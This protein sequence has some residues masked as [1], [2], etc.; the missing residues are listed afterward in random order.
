MFQDAQLDP[1]VRRYI[2][3]KRIVWQ[4]G[5]SAAIERSDRLLA[6][7]SG[8]AGLDLGQSCLLRHNGRAPGILLDFGRELH[9]GVQIIVGEISF[10]R[11]AR[12]RIRFGESV[13]EAMS[14][15]DESYTPTESYQNDHAIR[16]TVCELPWCGSREIGNTGFR[17]LRIDL[18]DKGCYLELVAV[19]AVLL[20]RDLEYKGSF[21]CDDERLNRIWRTGA[22]TVQLN[23]QGYLWDGIKR[24]RLVW[25]GDMHPETMVISAVFGEQGI[26]PASLD[27]VKARTPLPGWMNGISSYS[28]WWVIIQHSWF[29]YHGNLTYLQEQ[30]AYLTGLLNILVEQIDE[31]DREVLGGMRFLDWPSSNNP[32]AIHAG[33][34]SLL[35]LALEAGAALCDALGE[36]DTGARCRQAVEGLRRHRPPT[37]GAKQAGALMAL[38]GLVDAAEINCSLLAV[39]GARRMS[40]FYGY[41]VLQARALAGDYRGALDAIREYWGAMLDLGATTFWEHFD[42]DWVENACSIDRLVP[43]GM[44][45]I[46]ADFGEYCYQGTRHSLCHGWA[47]GPTA[48]LMEHI[49]GLVPLELGCR[50]IRVRPH[51]ADLA[52]ARGTFPTPLGIVRVEHVKQADGRITSRIHAPE[53]V[54]VER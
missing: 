50:K 44:R 24:D 47:G 7:Q 45:D 13:S 15:I 8:Q 21:E 26:V 32:E 11:P 30:R 22:Y 29:L 20:Y 16:D 48:W 3:P 9:G 12:V 51:L 38:A 52:W 18:L 27:L 46:H 36:A 40:P 54:V 1:R 53:R 35:I 34:Q 23:M 39:D 17:F 6:P 42:L 25:I 43:E 41:Y 31:Q 37:G 5:D 14:E 49:L 10:R 4:A 19:R 2:L 28:L 33:L